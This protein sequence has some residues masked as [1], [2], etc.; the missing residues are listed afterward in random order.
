MAGSTQQPLLPPERVRQGAARFVDSWRRSSFASYF[1]QPI[2]PSSLT[3][4]LLFFNVV[5]SPGG[6]ITALL[7][8]WG[9]DGQAMAVFRGGCASECSVAPCRGLSGG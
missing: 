3:F 9:F 5:L 8:Q 4:V 7:T 1:R 6:L 2:L